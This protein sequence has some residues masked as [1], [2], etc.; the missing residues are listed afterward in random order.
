MMISCTIKYKAYYVYF[1]LSPV[2]TSIILR[3]LQ[4]SHITSDLFNPPS[5]SYRAFFV[6]A[7]VDLL[8]SWP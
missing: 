5:P 7:F 6:V 8:L 4:H 2:V 1:P 3:G